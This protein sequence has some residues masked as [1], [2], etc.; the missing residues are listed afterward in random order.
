MKF[1][2]KNRNHLPAIEHVWI[3]LDKNKR[4]EFGYCSR[5]LT[6]DLLEAILIFDLQ[7]M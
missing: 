4:G 7:F 6:E 3:Y 5:A 1:Y 2:Q